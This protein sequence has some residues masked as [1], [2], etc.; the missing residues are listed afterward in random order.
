MGL[1]GW[2]RLIILLIGNLGCLGNLDYMLAGCD[3]FLIFCCVLGNFG[4]FADFGR[5]L[6]FIVY[7]VI[8]G[9]FLL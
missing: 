9:G 7:L 3:Y 6:C 1:S 8:L 2:V 5:K 4:Y